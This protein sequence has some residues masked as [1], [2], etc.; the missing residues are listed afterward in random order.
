[1]HK[2]PNWSTNDEQ[3]ILTFEVLL[4]MGKRDCAAVVVYIS[5]FATM[6]SNLDKL[7]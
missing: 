5:L 7:T 2:P 6:V 1:M 4:K 3:W